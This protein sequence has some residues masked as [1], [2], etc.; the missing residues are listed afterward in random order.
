MAAAQYA[1]LK[2]GENAYKYLKFEADTFT[3]PNLLSISPEGIALAPCDVYC[4]DSTLG[5]AQDLA[6]MLL[7]SH[8]DRLEFLPALHKEWSEGNIEGM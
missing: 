6:E 1:R 7:Q 5:I 4:I 8:S 2:D 3:W